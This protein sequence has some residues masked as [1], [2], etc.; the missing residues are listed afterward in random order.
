MGKT[1]VNQL[2]TLAHGTFRRDLLAGCTVYST[3]QSSERDKMRLNDA[4]VCL[5]SQ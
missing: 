3:F 5:F 1:K 2:V 4:A